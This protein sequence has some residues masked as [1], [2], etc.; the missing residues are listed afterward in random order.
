[1]YNIFI[2][3]AK[4]MYILNQYRNEFSKEEYEFLLSLINLELSLAHEQTQSF[5]QNDKELLN[6]N[7][8]YQIALY[9]IYNLIEQ[10]LKNLN[11]IKCIDFESNDTI[12][13]YI[14]KGITDSK[15]KKHQS[16]YEIASIKYGNNA[17]LPIELSTHLYRDFSKTESLYLPDYYI[18]MYEKKSKETSKIYQSLLENSL[19]KTNYDSSFIDFKP[20]KITRKTQVEESCLKLER[21][22]QGLIINHH[23]HQLQAKK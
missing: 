9:N 11:S 3:K 6:S 8:Y 18:E 2:S 4:I 23:I 1:M 20:I 7:I 17:P 16:I 15:D 14:V 13:K 10:A 5:L 21:K 19:L 12:E 22:A